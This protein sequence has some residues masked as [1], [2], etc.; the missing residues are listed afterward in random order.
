MKKLYLLFLI[1]TA[2]FAG[3]SREIKIFSIG[4]KKI[5]SKME[6]VIYPEFRK[7]TVVADK[8]NS[9]ILLRATDMKRNWKYTD[10]I[11]TL[12]FFSDYDI[13][14]REEEIISIRFDETVYLSDT[15]RPYKE[16]K[17]ITLNTDT[18]MEYSFSDFFKKNSNY[19]EF[20]NSYIKDYI[21]I[22]NID[23]LRE[24]GEIDE[25]QEFYLTET[26]FVIYYQPYVYTTRSYGPLIIYLPYDKVKKMIDKD[27][28]EL[29]TEYKEE[30]E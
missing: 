27:Y 20:I 28:I 26:A 3:C 30:R 12:K 8:I 17:S 25:N 2:V 19:K 23:M 9:D 13:K 6:R 21:K 15:S 24:F 22:R 16:I 4:E 7:S 5:H 18:G 11:E 10:E 29:F 1:M 14:F